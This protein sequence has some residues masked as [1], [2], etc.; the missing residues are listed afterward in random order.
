[1][2][3]K[4]CISFAFVNQ[5]E[6]IDRVP[7]TDIDYIKASDELGAKSDSDADSL[8]KNFVLQVA[9]N[10]EGHN[11]GRSYYLRTWSK[12]VHDD[13]F[14]LLDQ[15]VKYARKRSDGSSQF[16]RAQH[17]VRQIYGHYICQC[18]FALIIV[19]VSWPTTSNFS[20]YSGMRL[21]SS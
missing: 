3:A 2:L 19:G 7:L 15:L 21:C 9:T 4:E 12:E 20:L 5:N 8:Q 13:I 17:K 1:M 18:I 6:E 16:E 10:P 14:P 11:S